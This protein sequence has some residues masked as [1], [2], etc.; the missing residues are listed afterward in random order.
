MSLG[1]AEQIDKGPLRKFLKKCRQK[2]YHRKLKVRTERRRAKR[3]P[4]CNP[5]YNKYKGWIL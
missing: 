4:E 1:K 2:K 5:Q 3:D